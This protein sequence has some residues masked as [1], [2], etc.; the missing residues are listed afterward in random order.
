MLPKLYLLGPAI[1]RTEQIFIH[2]GKYVRSDTGKTSI[3]L[4]R[5]M[6]MET[7][8]MECKCPWSV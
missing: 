1:V 8:A 3:P 5:T 6:E 4:Q 7:S 2:V